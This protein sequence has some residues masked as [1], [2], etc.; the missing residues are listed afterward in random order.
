MPQMKLIIGLMSLVAVIIIGIA[1]FV[2]THLSSINLNQSIVLIVIAVVGLL[3]IMG[4]IYLI[5]RNVYTK[6]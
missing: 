5:M 2:F 6:K 4:I 1:I 3:I